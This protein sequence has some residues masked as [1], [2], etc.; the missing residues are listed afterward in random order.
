MS[1][2]GGESPNTNSRSKG[3]AIKDVGRYLSVHGIL[4]KIYQPEGDLKGLGIEPMARK[5]SSTVNFLE[6]V[7]ATEK[8]A[9]IKKNKK[10]KRRGPATSELKK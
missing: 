3:K 8:T 5:K 1:V 10:K 2:S 7:A 9:K 4:D 6:S